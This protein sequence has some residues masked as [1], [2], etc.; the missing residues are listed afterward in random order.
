MD[1]RSLSLLHCKEFNKD[2]CLPP[3]L[4]LLHM[5]PLEVLGYELFKQEEN[6]DFSPVH[7]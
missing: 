2:L 5:F 3:A 6:R 7:E 4:H 1:L